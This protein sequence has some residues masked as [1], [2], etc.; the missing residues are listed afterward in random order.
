VPSGHV[1]AIL[2]Q[3]NASQFRQ[4]GSRLY[5]AVVGIRVCSNGLAARMDWLLEWIGCLPQTAFSTLQGHVR[6]ASCSGPPCYLLSLPR[7]MHNRPPKNA[8]S[9]HPSLIGWGRLLKIVFM[10]RFA[11]MADGEPYVAAGRSGQRPAKRFEL[12]RTACSIW[13]R[14]GLSAAKTAWPSHT[15]K[16]PPLRAVFVDSGLL[17]HL[18]CSRQLLFSDVSV[19]LRGRS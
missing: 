3:A 4:L 19:F 10:G 13:V 14:N 6:R 11:R 9:S 1:H 5:L 15:N 18:K 2:L 8:P 12:H 16:E 17:S 7:A